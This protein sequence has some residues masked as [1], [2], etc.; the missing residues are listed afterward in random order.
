MRT[1]RVAIATLSAFAAL[2][3]ARASDEPS[4]RWIR[5]HAV[6]LKTPEAGHGFADMQPLKKII[7]NARIVAL[8][9]ATHGTREFF[10]LKHRM[11]EFL[12]SEMGFTVF[13]IEANMPE[14]YRL[15]DFVLK[16]EG[17]PAKLLRGMYFWTWDTEEVLEMIHWMRRLNESGKGRVEFTG[18]DMQTPKVAWEIVRDFVALKDPDYTASLLEASDK[19]GLLGGGAGGNFGVATASF[20]LKPAAGKRV[21]YSGY[22]KTSG[23]TT[24]WAGLW[25]RV[26][27][28]SGAPM[29]FDNMQTRGATGTADWKRYEIELPVEPGAKNIA[30]GVLHTGNGTAWFDGLAVEL[31]GV[32]YLD[33]SELDLD[34]ESASPTGFRTGGNGYRSRLDGE[35]FHS[36]KQSL[37]IR[38]ALDRETAA[39]W[40]G[41]VDHLETARESYRTK[42]A[43]VREIDWAIQNA[44]V[45]LQGLQL[46]MDEVAR[47]RSMAENVKWILDQSP[48]SKVVLWAHN[49]H[50]AKNAIAWGSGP[51]EPMGSFLR[52]AFGD[53]MVV[54]GFAFNQGSFQALNQAGKG[55]KDFTVS[56]APPGSLDAG[57]AAAA[58][59]LF[60]VDLRRAPKSGS[61][62]RLLRERHPSR[63]IGA[64]YSAANPER[65]WADINATDSFDAL[66]FVEKTSAARKNPKP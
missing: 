43:A 10:Q 30:F 36:G 57:L 28:D 60:T 33:K 55:L 21:R 16:G 50:V 62:A 56:P 24:G 29:A 53:R 23:I 48:E 59:P 31:D 66:L 12:V 15:N 58:I 22:I 4:V 51:S 49:A 52:K 6:R 45:V 26:D 20:P 2:A 39:S 34:F 27:G 3:V 7:G 1:R 5:Q 42:G 32:P 63:N 65:F 44:R 9:E 13:S 14:A 37:Q 61:V 25:W 35:V 11:L 8:G 46:R 18:F 17:D 41:V 38:N 54:F 64:F 40:K 19:V 47:D